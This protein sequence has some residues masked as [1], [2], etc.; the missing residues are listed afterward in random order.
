MTGTDCTVVNH[1]H[2]GPLIKMGKIFY[3]VNCFKFNIENENN[4]SFS[5]I[6]EGIE[7]ENCVSG[8]S[9]GSDS[10]SLLNEA[11]ANTRNA[12][13]MKKRVGLG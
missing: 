1:D 13:E 8:A 6:D 5:G 7:V 4:H 11:A 12:K 10:S 2:D 9:S 3:D